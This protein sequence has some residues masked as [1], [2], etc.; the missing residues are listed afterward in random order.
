MSRK[1]NKKS[2]VVVEELALDNGDFR[3]TFAGHHGF[4]AA[5]VVF[6]FGDDTWTVVSI[7]NK[8]ILTV[9]KVERPAPPPDPPLRTRARLALRVLIGNR[10]RK[11]RA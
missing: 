3:L 2:P 6:P 10:G 4:T 5:G 11:A 1:K 9:R 7:Q 8:Y